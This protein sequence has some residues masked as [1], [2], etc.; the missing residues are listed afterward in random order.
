ALGY[1]KDDASLPLLVGLL[2]DPLDRVRYAAARELYSFSIEARLAQVDLLMAA[3]AATAKPLVPLDEEDPLNLT[4]SH[5]VE[6]LFHPGG[7]GSRGC[8]YQSDLVGIDRDLLYPAIRAALANP[9][10][11]IRGMPRIVYD[12]LSREDVEAIADGVVESTMYEAPADRMFAAS[13][14]NEGLAL[15]Q[16]HNF[17]E[18]VPLAKIVTNERGEKEGLDPLL[19]YAA[20]SL[21]VKPDPEIVDWLNVLIANDILTSVSNWPEEGTTNYPQLILDAIAADT[22]PEV[23]TPF[24]RIYS[25]YKDDDTLTLPTDRTV[26]RVASYDY[27]QGD[28]VYTWRKVHGAGEVTFVPNGTAAAV[29]TTVI[30]DGTPSEYLFEVTMSD[31]RGLTE[32]TE[33]VALTLYEVGGT[34]PTNNP[35]TANPQSIT[36]E[37]GTPTQIILTGSD[38]EGLP[39]TYSVTS[40]PGNGTLSGTAPSLVYTAAANYTGADSITFEVMDSEGQVDTATVSVTVNALASPVGLAIYE[41]FDYPVHPAVLNGASGSSE[42]GL[43]GTWTAGGDIYTE[44]PG[45]TYGTLP[46]NG[47]KLWSRGYNSPGA[48]RPINP[49]A[50]AG[51]GLLDDGATLWFSVLIGCDDT[52]TRTIDIA[53]ANASFPYRHYILDDGAEPGTGLGLHFDDKEFRA[54]QYFD[55]SQGTTSDAKLVGDWDG[56]VAGRMNRYGDLRLVVVKITWGAS[57][58]TVEVYLPFEDMQL[59]S[60]PSSTLIADVDQSKFDVL[61]FSRGGDIWIDEIRFGGTL[62]SVLQ[63]T[64]VQSSPIDSSA[65]TPDPM[66][67]EVAPYVSSSSAISMT[68]TT[69]HDPLG[70]EYYFTCTAGGGNDSGW[71]DSNVY[72]DTGLTPG[73]AYSYTVKARDK[74]PGHNETLPSSAQSATIPVLGTVPGVVGLPQATAES[75]ITD[76]GMTVGNVTTASSYSLTVPAGHVLSQNPVASTSTAYGTA[77]DL[78]ISI[79]QDPALPVLDSLNIEDDQGGA[80]VVLPVMITYTLTFSQDMDLSTID[81]GD[82]ENLGDFPLIIGA[83]NQPSPGVVT[84]EVTPDT[85]DSGYLHFAISEGAVIKDASGNDLNT[86]LPIADDDALAILRP[87]NYLP[88]VDAGSD[89]TVTATTPRPWTP[90]L[91]STAA[92]YDAADE[93][94]ITDSEGAVSL[95]NDKSGNGNHATQS[96]STKRPVTGTRMING[97]NVLDFQ[98]DDTSS[99]QQSLSIPSMDL[100][101]KEVWSVILLD[102]Q[103]GLLEP[104]SNQLIMGGGSNV[105]V[106]ISPSTGQMRF[107][108]GANP[109][110]ADSRSTGSIA[111]NTPTLAAWL[112]HTTTKKFSINGVLEDTGDSYNAGGTMPATSIGRGQYKSMDGTIG[113][114][115]ITG[116]LSASDRETTEGYLA[117]KWGLVDD[118]PVAHPYKTEAPFQ[119]VWDVALNGTVSDSDGDSLSTSWSV[120]SGPGNV[121]FA[122]SGAVDTT[123]TFFVTGDYVLELVAD[124]GTSQASDQVAIT[125][126]NLADPTVPTLA[127]SDIVDD[128]GGASALEGDTVTYTLTFSEDIYESIVDVSDFSNAG[129]ATVTIDSVVESSPGVFTVVVTASNDGTLQLQVNQGA[130]I[131]DLGGNPLDTSLAIVDDTTITIDEPNV[132][133]TWTT[134]PINESDATEDAAY[135]ST[136]ADDASDANAGDTLTFAKVGGPTWLSVAANGSLSGTPPAGEVGEDSFTVSVSD[137]IAPAVEATLNIN[138]TGTPHYQAWIEGYGLAPEDWDFLSDPDGD[139]LSNGLEAWFGTHPGQKNAGLAFL[140]T[141]GSTSTFTHPRNDNPP[142]D[143]S[144]FY[145]WSPNLTDWYGSGS[146]PVGGPNLTFSANT[147]GTTT[148]VTLNGSGS[149]DYFFVRVNVQRD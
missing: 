110:T 57:S 34:L 33:T 50:L 64:A 82:F 90:L 134:N 13:V 108:K 28:S 5:L 15:M 140:A 92:W 39:L 8:L 114:I 73:V 97:L 129:T 147:V 40:G 78:E 144:A 30:L 42:I 132:A 65:P 12:A 54:A 77:V 105:Q 124:D 104:T 66:T 11:A 70:V 107:W 29:A 122:D 63:G 69:A 48:S 4:N 136:L 101:G 3:C 76:A 16:S 43:D 31:S 22:S 46:T 56:D 49:S 117:H 53:L 17:A 133:P 96:T 111:A 25:I 100:I 68:A 149:L 143:L 142:S 91:I 2:T 85:L 19:A 80:P 71:Q 26:L 130:L 121:E 103:T 137:G 60:E 146:G 131:T 123:A 93:G 32:V 67:F 87:P 113:E 118:L 7:G 41:P 88:V 139:R 81:A 45:Y 27:A 61:T 116:T 112:G 135:N 20:D 148:T 86:S 58:D 138:V 95:W 89:Q 119:E 18:G 83:I 6:A 102:D 23:P 145:E 75:M 14:R 55:A 94:S 21:L 126:V 106:G 44:S 84:V 128:R 35:P 59:P 99:Q 52:W 72:T 125:I 62:Q 1:I 109:Y 141:D 9:R 47:P 115:V 74:H 37:P 79:G 120:L 51:S 36:V 38:P 98:Y 127:S 10:G 24:K